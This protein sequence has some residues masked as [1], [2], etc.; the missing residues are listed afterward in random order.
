MYAQ[1]EQMKESYHLPSALVVMLFG[2][3]FLPHYATEEHFFRGWT[4]KQTCLRGRG[5][6]TCGTRP[7]GHHFA[8][9]PPFL[10]CSCPLGAATLLLVLSASRKGDTAHT[11]QGGRHVLKRDKSSFSSRR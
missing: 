10:F 1:V 6:I 7:S 4:M 11:T 3:V 9:E 5:S 2:L 8:Q